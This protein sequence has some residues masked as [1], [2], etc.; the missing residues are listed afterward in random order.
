[1]IFVYSISTVDTI[2]RKVIQKI[3]FVTASRT[4]IS[5]HEE[6]RIKV[7]GDGICCTT[8]F[9]DTSL[10]SNDTIVLGGSMLEDC[11]LKQFLKSSEQFSV[12]VTIQKSAL[13]TI[14]SNS[15]GF[16]AK[17]IRIYFNNNESFLCKNNGT[18]IKTLKNPSEV[19]D[20][21]TDMIELNC[22]RFVENSDLGNTN[23]F[24]QVIERDLILHL[25][26]F[27]ITE[28]RI[29]LYVYRMP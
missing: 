15:D 5:I 22:W 18:W 14:E 3:K 2:D 26:I 4:E 27:Q 6:L 29:F 16:L 23:I 7:C 13:P 9:L 25:Y 11:R 21:A 24:Y 12:T 8:L 20:N 28:Q 1:M 17:S 19:N 10:G